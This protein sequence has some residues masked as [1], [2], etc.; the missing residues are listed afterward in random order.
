MDSTQAQYGVM[1]RNHPWGRYSQSSH[2]E[3]N[4]YKYDLMLLAEYV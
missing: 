4:L 1:N 2:L 3:K